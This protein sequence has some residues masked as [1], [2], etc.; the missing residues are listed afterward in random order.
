[1]PRKRHKPE[2]IV[3][4]QRQ[5]N[6]LV[7]QGHGIVDAICQIDVSEVVF[8]T[9]CS[10][11]RSSTCCVKPRSSSR[12]GVATTTPS[13]RPSAR[14]ARLQVTSTGDVCA[15]IRCVASSAGHASITECSQLTFRLDHSMQADQ[16]AC[17]NGSNASHSDARRLCAT[18]SLL[19]RLLSSPS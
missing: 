8:V 18:T 17:S 13:V 15:V 6:I 7:S 10:T 5:V 2:E 16:S 11:A 3:T 14:L 1:M 12:A 4:K 9:N 19:W